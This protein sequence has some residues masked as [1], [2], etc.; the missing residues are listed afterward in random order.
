MPFVTVIKTELTSGW[1]CKQGV[2]VKTKNEISKVIGMFNFI[3]LISIYTVI[4]VLP[5][6]FEFSEM[7]DMPKT[8]L[9]SNKKVKNGGI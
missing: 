6:T 8:Q 1:E 2:A 3:F 4:H 7:F 9:L 5:Y